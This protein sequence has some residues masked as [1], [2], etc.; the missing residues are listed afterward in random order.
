M[1]NSHLSAARTISGRYTVRKLKY[2]LIRTWCMMQSRLEIASSG[3]CFGAGQEPFKCHKNW[4]NHCECELL[5]FLLL[6]CDMCIVW[7]YAI[8][9]VSVWFMPEQLVKRLDAWTPPAGCTS[10]S[11]WAAVSKINATTAAICI[12][13]CEVWP[14]VRVNGGTYD[15]WML[16]FYL[17]LETIEIYLYN[18]TN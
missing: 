9:P 13:E 17:M 3:T 11:I 16:Q 2:L 1:R 7:N 18:V 4:A 10:R 14:L 8:A 12:M 15:P 6:W 5:L